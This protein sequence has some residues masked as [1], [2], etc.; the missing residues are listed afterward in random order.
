MEAT[1]AARAIAP[2]CSARRR[3][4]WRS[5]GRGASSH[6]SRPPLPAIAWRARGSLP[7]G[8]KS[9]R[10]WPGLVISYGDGRF[11]RGV[12]IVIC[13]REILEAEIVDIF[14]SGI[15]LHPRERSKI[16]GE[17]LTR[18]FEMILVKV[19]IAESVDELAGAQLAD[20]RDH[21]RE[22]RIRGD[23][24]GHA[25]KQIGAAL[26]KL[27]AQL[28]VAHVKLEENVAGR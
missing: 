17:L 22:Q 11:D 3:H 24:E 25:E 18:L 28:A 14:H 26:I 15:E 16:A 21:H 5:K 9:A 7:K 2:G 27:A 6:L 13:Q 20:L 23:V 19:Q 4:R 12:R 8:N 1:P 10:E